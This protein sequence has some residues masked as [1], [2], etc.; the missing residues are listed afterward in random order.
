MCGK[1]AR[2]KRFCATRNYQSKKQTEPANSMPF[3]D[4]CAVGWW[5]LLRPDHT[6]FDH[7]TSRS[8]VQQMG[9]RRVTAGQILAARD[10]YGG[11]SQLAQLT[12]WL[13]L[14]PRQDID[15]QPTV[16]AGLS[17]CSGIVSTLIDGSHNL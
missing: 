10:Y 6:P 15:T 13:A 17:H 1:I 2:I 9:A 7:D 3:A 16:T 4:F 12:G 8:H 14:L 5:W 11:L